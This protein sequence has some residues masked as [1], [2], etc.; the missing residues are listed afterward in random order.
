M[1]KPF[2]NL[3]EKMTP[4]RRERIE[5]RARGALREINLR[6]LR[7]AFAL[8]QEQ[9]APFKSHLLEH[10]GLHFNQNNQRILERAL[11][12]RVQALQIDSLSTY[13]KYLAAPSE[14]YDELNKLIG[15]L[16]VGET[17]F[18][19][20]RSHREAL[21]YYVI[22]GLIEKNRHSQRLRF[23]SAGCSTG[24]EPYSLAILLLEHFPELV[25]WDIQI[26]A[27]DI[28]KRA[29]RHAREG[30]Y[31]ERSLRMMKQPLCRKYFSRTE[32][33][34][35]VSRQARNMVRFDYLNL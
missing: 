4:E 9:L 14:N 7:Q 19:R 12:R 22:P 13:F 23:W 20:Y 15:L 21:L 35:Q 17:S 24:E 25:G 3:L 1:A 5:A 30:V 11:L 2:K 32:N 18:F 16:T 10:S 29:L 26:Q 33:H 8:T 28:N 34:F 6:E 27:T 31:G